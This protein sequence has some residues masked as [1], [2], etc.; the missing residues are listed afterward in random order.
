MTTNDQC[1]LNEWQDA[2]RSVVAESGR[3]QA[4]SIVAAVLATAQSL[5]C[6]VG[7]NH[8]TPYLNTLSNEAQERL[9]VEDIPMLMRSIACVRWN[10]IVTVLRAV[11][12]S[13]SIGG[14][15][16]S[17]ASAA[18]LYEV[19]FNYFYRGRSGSLNTGDQFLGDLVYFQGHSSPGIYARSFLEGRL[20]ESQMDRFRREI[21]GGGLSSYPHPWLMP[22][23][24]QFPT[25]SMG[26]G[27]LTAIYQAQ[28]LKYLE[29]RAL[30]P[31]QGRKV[32]AYCGDGEM[33]EPE[34]VGAIH[35]AAR[36]QL[37]NLIF[38]I[39]CN[40]QRLDGP[41]WGNGQIIQQFESLFAGA[42]WRVIKVIWGGAWST[43]LEQDET[44]RLQKRMA[45]LRDGDFQTMS[46]RGPAYLRKAFFGVDADLAAMVADW[47]DEQLAG[48][49]DGGHDPQQVFA[50]YHEAMQTKGVPT[51]L[52]FKTVKGYGMGAGGEAQNTTH[53]QK[54]LSDAD[55]E[56]F[57]TRFTPPVTK[58][59]RQSLAFIAPEAVPEEVAFMQSKRE[60]LHGYL[61][62]RVSECPRISIPDVDMFKAQLAGTGDREQ[63]TTMVIARMFST[64]LKNK[65]I[66]PY[67]VPIFAD[68]TR[69]FGMESYFRQL[70]IYQVDGQQY[71]PEDRKALMYYR[72]ASDG[73]VLQQG[74]SEPGAMASWT[75]AGTAYATHAVPLIPLYIYYAMFGFQR[76]GDL[77]WAAADQRA[78]GFIV[79]GL[80]GRTSLPGEGLQHQDGHNL[81]M[82]SAVPS[83]ICYDPCFAYETAIIMHDGLRR[84]YDQQ[85]DVFYYL[86]ATNENYIH[87]A[88]PEHV[89]HQDVLRGMYLYQAAE[90]SSSATNV[91]LLGSG[92]VLRTTI[93][94]A[95]LLRAQGFAVN[96]WSVTSFSELRRDIESCQRRHRLQ[97]QQPAPLSHVE[98]CLQGHDG[99]VVAVS[100]HIKLNANQI[101]PAIKGSFDVLGTDGYGRSDTR[102]ALRSFFEID[103]AMIAYTAMVAL[104]REGH[105]T[106]E[107]LS[108]AAS[109]WGVS[110]EQAEPVTQ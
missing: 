77:V 110:C 59:Q 98:Q 99:P 35:I 8:T 64:L 80:S 47:S 94:A 107:K 76:I 20:P 96:V 27:P 6:Q 70:G 4:E 67:L 21:G 63:S 2:L 36:E 83:C 26:L 3:S 49:I 40:L 79:G 74:I 73:Q 45:E 53:Q 15:I 9:P 23:Y 56:Q 81:L 75:A 65:D 101:A 102:E 42:G 60:Q 90:K 68:E 82:F 19:G 28:L 108:D 97:P 86:T 31:A 58:K 24:W 85:E 57:V 62:R 32:W 39:N 100:D 18:I 10:A 103:A 1:E 38:V 37:D 78:R 92:V 109:L 44:G 50:A 55:L 72:E 13:G 14:H 12:K 7:N 51:L 22:E 88:I 71:E 91:Q 69:T 46:A 17:F 33:N 25:V 93:E 34:S 87:P 16:A 29:N 48:L 54:K 61:P 105:V 89:S 30:I 106:A 5:N 41:V 66:A 52:L 11:K 43:L 84:M 104:F 95:A